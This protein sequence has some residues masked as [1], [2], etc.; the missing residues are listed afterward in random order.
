MRHRKILEPLKTAIALH[1]DGINAPTVSAKGTGL[2]G[3]HIIQ[4]AKEHGIPLH[5]NSS[6][7]E[8]LSCIPLGEEIPAELFEI[9]AEVLAYIYFLD[10]VQSGKQEL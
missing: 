2:T 1:F 6:L 10:D 5:E 8:T 9:V 4:L 3:E 7:A